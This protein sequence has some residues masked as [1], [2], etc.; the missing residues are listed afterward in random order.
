MISCVA[1]IAAAQKQK[2]EAIVR[3]RKFG[4]DG[5]RASITA[6]RFV[7][8][9]ELRVGDRHVLE[10]FVI[11]RLLAES[12]SIRCQG[13]VVIALAF[14][15]ERLAEIVEIVGPRFRFPSAHQAVPE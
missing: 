1:D 7:E 13:S 6:Y 3:A 2:C 8:L 12:E 4:L 5:K 11:V 9:T 10:D 14:E 15:G